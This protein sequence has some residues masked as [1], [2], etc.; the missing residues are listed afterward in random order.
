MLL[1]SSDVASVSHPLVEVAMVM[2]N[3]VETQIVVLTWTVV[4]SCLVCVIVGTVTSVVIGHNVRWVTIE[5]F[6][7]LHNLAIKVMGTIV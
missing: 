2:W 6:K 4:G 3:V 7:I 1:S 5:I